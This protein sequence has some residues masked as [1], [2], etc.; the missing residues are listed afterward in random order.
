MSTEHSVGS[1][2]RTPARVHVDKPTRPQT[3]SASGEMTSALVLLC[4]DEAAHPTDLRLSAVI[5]WNPV[6]HV[7]SG[8]GWDAPPSSKR[9]ASRLPNVTAKAAATELPPM[10]R[11]DHP[12]KPSAATR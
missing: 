3:L 7:V 10:N 2:A 11:K 1:H 4:D 6:M 9:P 5:G 12:G 8:G